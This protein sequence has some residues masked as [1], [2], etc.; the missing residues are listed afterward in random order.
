MQAISVYLYPNLIDAYMSVSPIQ[1]ERYR[2]VYNRNIK[3]YRGVDN[4]IDIQV[5]N[6]DQKATATTGYDTV[7]NLISR[8]TQELV[9]KKDAVSMEDSTAYAGRFY[10]SLTEGDIEDIDPGF[11]QFS[12]TLESRTSID[13]TA[14]IVAEKKP[15]YVDSQYGVL[16][17]VEVFKDVYGEPQPSF[18]IREF[19]EYIPLNEDTYYISGLIDARPEFGN[20][21]SLHSFQFNMTEYVG[22]LI[23]QGSISNGGNPEVWADLE[24]LNFSQATDISYVN[25]TGKYNFFR[26][27]HT[28]ETGTVDSILYR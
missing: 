2:R 28:P 5:R 6:S 3:V 13:S 24:T 21:N 1:D 10:V 19:K 11:Y 12:L 27:K 14:Y 23:V 26:F 9:L 4:R 20:T 15:L 7:F 16:G 22:E 25:I 18:E 8:E 17:T